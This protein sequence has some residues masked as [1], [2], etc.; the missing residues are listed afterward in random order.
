MIDSDCAE[1]TLLVQADVDGELTPADTARVECHL[2]R[3]PNCAALQAQLISLSGR[4]RQEVTYHS[5]PSVA[6]E[7]LRIAVRARLAAMAPPEESPAT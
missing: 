2:E 6:Q 3:C 5:A 4:I 1:M 7:K